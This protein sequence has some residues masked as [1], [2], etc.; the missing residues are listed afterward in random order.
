[1]ASV[2]S[3]LVLQAQLVSLVFQQ[4]QCYSTTNMSTSY[5]I[6]CGHTAIWRAVF[7]TKDWLEVATSEFHVN[8]L[9]IGKNLHDWQRKPTY[10]ILIARDMSGDL[11]YKQ[12]LFFNSLEK[13]VYNKFTQE[14]TFRCGIVMNVREV[15]TGSDGL[16]MKD[17]SLI[18]SAE[19]LET[20]Y[21]FW[22][23]IERKLRT[24]NPP[25]IIGV[26]GIIRRLK[27]ISPICCLNLSLPGEPCIQHVFNDSSNYTVSAI[28]NEGKYT[29]WEIRNSGLIE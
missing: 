29:G 13:H 16:Q 1:M 11:Q 3:I 9:F 7:K 17:L 5:P 19:R 10:L 2:Y 23:D 6:E 28:L 8:P 14:V 24:I 18:F 20:G 4:P 22:S 12:D 25:Y 26:G 15:I 21:C 27:D